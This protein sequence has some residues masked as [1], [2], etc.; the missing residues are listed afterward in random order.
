LIKA[1]K[2]FHRLFSNQI[3]QLIHTYPIYKLNKDGRPFWSLPKRPP[4]K[5]D[6]DP[7]N[8]LHAS[9]IASCACLFAVMYKIDIKKEQNG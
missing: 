9:F 2:K 3:L 8:M 7:Q 1:R 6:F 5:I 4:R